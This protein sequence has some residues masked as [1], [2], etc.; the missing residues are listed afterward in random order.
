[1]VQGRQLRLE[2]AGEPARRRGVGELGRE[3]DPVGLRRQRRVG[4]AVLPTKTPQFQEAGT[5]MSMRVLISGARA[6]RC[7][8]ALP[9]RGR[10]GA[11]V[12]VALPTQS[13][14]GRRC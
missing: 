4:V 9:D 2:L 1:V 3:R 7:L 8:L 10:S 6:C 12:P 5:V 14:I 11:P 13:R